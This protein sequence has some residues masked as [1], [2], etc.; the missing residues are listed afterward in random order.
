MPDPLGGNLPQNQALAMG[1]PEART[2]STRG[3]DVPSRKKFRSDLAVACSAVARSQLEDQGRSSTAAGRTP[4]TRAPVTSNFPHPAQGNARGSFCTLRPVAIFSRLRRAIFPGLAPVDFQPLS[5]SA[6]ARVEARL[7][8]PARVMPVAELQELLDG[9]Q[10]KFAA[11]CERVLEEVKRRCRDAEVWQ[12]FFLDLL[13]EEGMTYDEGEGMGAQPVEPDEELRRLIAG[14]RVYPQVRS[15]F[16]W[17]LGYH[18]LRYALA[19]RDRALV[20]AAAAAAAEDF[21]LAWDA[22]K[23]DEAKVS[24]LGDLGGALALA[25]D[26]ELSRLVCDYAASISAEEA[27]RQDLHRLRREGAPFVRESFGQPRE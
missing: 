22:A 4:T 11:E 6:R 18:T 3:S 2:R 20:T 9:G 14:V 5:G 15:R 27:V 16:A 21:L 12:N 24:A 17:E 8:Q 25:G 7:A 23:D 1:R 26:A 10:G 19:T 13:D